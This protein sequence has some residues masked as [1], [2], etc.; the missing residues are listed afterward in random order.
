MKTVNYVQ[1]GI[2]MF[3]AV[4]FAL[5]VEGKPFT[6]AFL[7]VLVPTIIL[8]ITIGIIVWIKPSPKS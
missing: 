1:C 3:I 2:A 6:T 5:W 8:V 7:T 4:V